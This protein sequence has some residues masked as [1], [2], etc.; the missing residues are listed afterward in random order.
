M[1]P[2][3]TKQ[4]VLFLYSIFV[5]KNKANIQLKVNINCYWFN[6]NLNCRKCIAVTTM[7]SPGTAMFF[8]CMLHSHR[9][10][11]IM[12]HIHMGATFHCR[13]NVHMPCVTIFL[14]QLSPFSQRQKQYDSQNSSSQEPVS[15]VFRFRH[16]LFGSQ[17]NKRC[18]CSENPTVFVV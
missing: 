1:G 17:V 4:N 7:L 8:L 14:K 15:K 12:V 9:K 10:A 5:F 18:M 2:C 11:V 16:S 13:T 3:W 6:K